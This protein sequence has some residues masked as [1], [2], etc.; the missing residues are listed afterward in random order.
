M[1]DGLYVSHPRL[2]LCL[3]LPLLRTLMS[4]VCTCVCSV[5]SVAESL[6][7]HRL[8]PSRLL[9]PWDSPGTNTEVGCHGLLHGD[10]PEPGIEPRSPASPSL[11]ADSLP[12]ESPGKPPECT[13]PTQIIQDHCPPQDP[14]CNRICKVHF[15]KR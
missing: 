8:Q 14:S 13:G 4:A 7:P 3:P 6:Q 9:C 10:L 2:L 1:V 12:T 15:A 5:T 11:Q